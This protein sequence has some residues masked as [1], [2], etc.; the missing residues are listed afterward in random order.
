M[1]VVGQPGVVV[2]IEKPALRSAVGARA[3]RH[4]VQA[5]L[6]LALVVHGVS[7][8]SGMQELVAIVIARSVAWVD[9][10]LEVSLPRPCIDSLG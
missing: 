7:H 8:P 1:H 2:L 10:V 5:E 4:S 9:A 6:Y 3:E